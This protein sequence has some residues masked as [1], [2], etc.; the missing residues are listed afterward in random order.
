MPG[1]WSI[2]GGITIG[3][4]ITFEVIRNQIISTESDDE[5]ITESDDELITDQ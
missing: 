1:Q 3:A 4:G 5:L 2:G